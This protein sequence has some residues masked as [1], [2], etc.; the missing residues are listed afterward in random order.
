MEKKTWSIESM[1]AHGAAD[2]AVTYI[3]SEFAGYLDNDSRNGT[4]VHD[5]YVDNE[6]QRWFKSRA[7]LPNGKSVSMEEYIF[8]RKL[9]QKKYQ[10]KRT[11]R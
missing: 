8:G 3:G 11:E 9:T 2:R 5:Y 6:G 10:K 7:I 1:Q 4:R